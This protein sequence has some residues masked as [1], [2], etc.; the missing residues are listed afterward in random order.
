M[1]MIADQKRANANRKL[2]DN[3]VPDKVPVELLHAT[4]RSLLAEKVSIRNLQ[5]IIEAIAEGRQ[6]T[7]SWDLIYEHVRIRLGFQII[8]KFITS[9]KRLNVVQL[10]QDWEDIF[11]TYQIKGENSNR[12]EIALPPSMLK[13]LL[14]SAAAKIAISST[15]SDY[16]AIITTSKRRRFLQTIFSAKGISN[17][18]LSYDEIDHNVTLNLV[19]TIES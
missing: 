14:D 18:V 3:M 11:F 13:E 7:Q 5:L 19:G 8:E 12:N 2:L 4:L 10:S 17:P 9:D 1:T 16:I 6:F 15:H